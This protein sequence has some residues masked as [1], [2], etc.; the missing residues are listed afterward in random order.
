MDLANELAEK[1][2]RHFP[3]TNEAK[4]AKLGGRRRLESVLQT[5]IDDLDSN[6]VPARLGGF[7]R[8]GWEMYFAGV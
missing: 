6:L 4:L 3:P 2:S 1:I 7:V 8:R 5:V